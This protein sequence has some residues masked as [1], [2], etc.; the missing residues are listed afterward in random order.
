MSSTEEGRGVLPGWLSLGHIT[1]GF[2]RVVSRAIEYAGNDSETYLQKTHQLA[3]DISTG[4]NNTS[5]T[6]EI[7]GFFKASSRATLHDLRL[8]LRGEHHNLCYQIELLGRAKSSRDHHHAQ[9][10]PKRFSSQ[11][12][13]QI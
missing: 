12:S 11:S 5:R 10:N 8:A 9:N 1:L 7:T 6:E 4:D 13:L 3:G 2:F